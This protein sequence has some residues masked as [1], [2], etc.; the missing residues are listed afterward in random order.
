MD[1]VVSVSLEYRFPVGIRVVFCAAEKQFEFLRYG[2]SWRSLWKNDVFW[3]NN[4]NSWVI[5]T[6]LLWALDL[7]SIQT[8]ITVVGSL[9]SQISLILFHQ[10]CYVLV[11][12]Q[13][14]FSPL[15]P[16]FRSSLGICPKK[17]LSLVFLFIF[18]VLFLIVIDLFL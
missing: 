1:P 14:R 2:Y 17:L 9:L 18:Y 5:H 16:L 3:R 10:I 15:I 11:K 12:L 6:S 13:T 4:G 8:V 7:L